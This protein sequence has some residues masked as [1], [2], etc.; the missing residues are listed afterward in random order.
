MVGV[1][2]MLNGDT[3]VREQFAFLATGQP[4]PTVEQPSVK[5]NLRTTKT[6]VVEGGGATAEIARMNTKMIRQSKP[7]PVKQRAGMHRSRT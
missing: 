2:D 3:D 1:R 7:Q 6:I 4:L 5:G